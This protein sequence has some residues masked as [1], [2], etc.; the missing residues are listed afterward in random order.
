MIKSWYVKE[1]YDHI[2]Y[3]KILFRINLSKIRRFLSNGVLTVEILLYM[4]FLPGRSV[5]RIL[6]PKH[7]VREH[8]VLW[9]NKAEIL[10]LL[11]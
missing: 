10:K 5:I 1:F 3:Y 8:T 6:S 4:K 9:L 11:L 7:L 2:K